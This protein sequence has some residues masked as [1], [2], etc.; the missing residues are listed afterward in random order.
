MSLRPGNYTVES[1]RPLA[2]RGRR[3]QWRQTVDVAAGRDTVLEWSGTNAEEGDA[4]AAA[5]TPGGAPESDSG[6]LFHQ[7]QQ[8]VVAIWTPGTHASGFLV[9]A[10]GSSSPIN[11]ASVRRRR[12]RCS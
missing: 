4:D 9:D 5:A 7:W 10:R 2:F 12:R 8:S 11:A 6:F 1:D 3:Y